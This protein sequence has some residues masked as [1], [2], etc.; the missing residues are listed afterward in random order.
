MRYLHEKLFTF[1][2]N[3]LLARAPKRTEFTIK[4]GGK[5]YEL[6]NVFQDIED[7]EIF[8]KNG[9]TKI[10]IDGYSLLEYLSLEEIK[11]K[12]KFFCGGDEITLIKVTN[13]VIIFNDEK[14][15][16]WQ[17]H[18]LELI[19]K[20]KIEEIIEEEEKEEE[21]E[22]E[23]D[24]LYI[25]FSEGENPVVKKVENG[26]ETLYLFQGEIGDVMTFANEE[27]VIEYNTS[28]ETLKEI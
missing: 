9:I 6:N 13:P 16:G 19:T 11:D 1:E 5:D 22:K 21:V 26:E 3:A 23:K 15:S 17:E 28:D 24:G 8:N 7:I 20:H 18:L 27:K 10:V 4:T 25:Y 14:I 12:I 2:I